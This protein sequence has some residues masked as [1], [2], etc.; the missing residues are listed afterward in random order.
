MRDTLAVTGRRADS[1]GRRGP[2]ASVHALLLLLALGALVPAAGASAQPT[3]PLASDKL[4][5]QGTRL[6]IAPGDEEQTLNVAEGATV[7]TCFAGVC[8]AMASGDPRASGLVV[9][10]D[11]SGPE[12]PQPIT[13][14]TV[15]GGAFLL[16]GF[17][18]EGTYL[19]SNIRL[20]RAGGGEVLGNAS[21]STV[22]LEVR[23]ILLASATVRQLTLEELRARGIEITQQSFQAFSFDVGFVFRDTPV[24]I[25]LPV[26]F[27]EGSQVELLEKPQVRLDGLP[28]DVA[29]ALRRWQPPSLIPFRLEAAAP[30]QLAPGYEPEEVPAETKLFGV[31]VL[32]GKVSFLNQFLDASLLVVNGAPTGSAA[33]LANVTG[34]IRLPAAV[35]RELLRLA[36]TTPPV[37]AGQKVPVLGATGNA[38]L[39]PSEQGAASFTL[40]GLV[41]GTHVF[42]LAIE[43]DLERPGRD[44]LPLAGKLKAAVEVVDA[45]FNLSFNHPDVVREGEPYTLYATVTNLS[46]A[47][48]YL[49]TVE[50]DSSRITGAHKERAGDDFSPTIPSLAPGEGATFEYR[51]VADVTGRCVATTFQSAGPAEGVI[52][53]RTGVGEAGIPLSPSSLVLP[54]FTELLPEALVRSNIRLLGLAWSLAVAPPGSIPPELPRLVTTDVERRAVDL[55]EAGQ[56]LYLGDGLLSSLEALLLDQ[57]GN[58]HDLPEYDTLR[59]TLTKGRDAAEALASLLRQEQEARGLTARSLLADT[60][61]AMTWARPWIAATLESSGAGTA[62]TLEVRKLNGATGVTFLAYPAGDARALRSIPFGEVFDVFER[63]GGRRSPLAVVGRLS[64]EAAYAFVVH[65]PASGTPMPVTLSFVAPAPSGSGFVVVDFPSLS[66][67]PGEAWAVEVTRAAGDFRP[68]AFALVHLATGMPV[69]EAPAAIVRAVELPPFRLIGARQ[70]FVLDPYGSGVWYLFNRPPAK[71]DAEEEDRYEVETR[72]RGLDST[73]S[74]E[75]LERTATFTAAS[76]LLQ[77]SSERVLTVRFAQPVSAVIATRE[78]QPV[79]T[80]LHRI[81]AGVLRDRYGNALASPVPDIRIESGHVGGLVEGKVLA[82]TGQAVAGATLRLVRERIVPDASGLDSRVVHDLVAERT[83]GADGSFFF[84]FVEEPVLAVPRPPEKG[85]VQSGFRIQAVLPPGPDPLAPL[86]IEEVSSIIRL[87]S[88]LARINLSFLGRGTL[89]GRAVYDDGG[90]AIG[91]AVTAASTLFSEVRTAKAGADGGFRVDGLPVG[92]ITVTARDAEGRSASATVALGGPGAK[93]E[94]T[95]RLERSRPPRI[96]T[97][98]GRVLFRSETASGPQA[99]PVAGARV[100]VYSAGAPYGEAVTG[101]AGTFRFTGVPAGRVTLQAADFTRSR[102]AAIA[103]VDLAAEGSADATLILAASS[104]RSVAGKVLFHD[105]LAQADVPASGATVFVEGPGSFA[106]TDAAGDYRIDGVPAQGVGEAPYRVHAIDSVRRAEG[107]TVV[108]VTDASPDPVAAATIVLDGATPGAID[109]VVLDPLGRPAPGVTVTL[110]PIGETTTGADGTFS[111][112]GVPARAYTVAAHVGAGLEPRAIGWIGEAGTEVLFG[113]HRAFVTVR[114]RGAGTLRVRTRTTTAGVRS[115]LVYRPTWFS[116]Q[117]LVIRQKSTGIETTTDDDGRLALVLPV[118]ELSVT[119]ANPFHGTASFR[120]AIDF[121]GQVKEVDLLFEGSS[122]VAG[123]VVDVDGITPVP[124]IDVDLEA[125]G[126]IPQRQRTDELGAFRFELVPPGNVAVTAS[127]FRGAIQRTGRTYGRITGHGQLLDL[128]VSLKPQ[129]TVRG[130]VAEETA[131]GVFLPLSGAQVALQENDFP[132]RRFPAAPAF[133]TAGGDGRFEMGGVSA[134]RFTVV[135]RDPGQVSRL[136]SRSGE[137]K[138]DFD[139][140]EVGDL[141]LSG[142]V[143]ALSVLVRDPQ[144]G[145]PVPDAQVFLS[146]GEATVA[147]ADG[148]ASFQALSLGTY[149]AHVFHAP[150]GRGGRLG[151]IHLDHAG[152]DLEVVVLL[153]QRGR[154]SGVLFDD[155][156][157]TVPVGGGTVRLEGTVNGRLWGA[158]VTALASTSR[159]PGSSGTFAFDGLPVATYALSAGV[160]GSDRQAGEN[161]VLTP[162]AP[163]A[164][165]ALVLEPIRDVWVRL[166]SKEQSRGLVEV[167]PDP[168]RGDGVF[169]ISYGRHV[170]I[171]SGEPIPLTSRLAPDVP[172][173]GHAYRFRDVLASR[174]FWVRALESS[175][176]QRRA[177]V[178]SSALASG[179]GA[180]ADPYRI[181]L[182]ARGTVRVAV[183]D[184]GGVAA[185]GANVRVHA[186]NGT[187]EGAADAAGRA[188]FTAVEEGQV[189]V[190]ASV[191]GTPLGASIS[192]TLRWDD[193]VLD[194]TLTLSPV[195]SA[196]GTVHEAPGGDAWSGDPASLP[197]AGGIFVRIRPS[198][199]DEQLLVTS[200]DGAFRFSGL[201]AGPY[202]LEARSLD[203]ERVATA[204]GTL[205]SAHGTDYALPPVVLDGSR[206]RIVSVTPPNGQSLVSRTA[207]VE[208]V[209][210]EPLATAV[211]PSGPTSSTFRLSFSS[212]QATGTW[213]SSLDGAGRQVVRFTPSPRY[214]NSTTYMLAMVGGSGGVRDREGR[215]LT[216]S[217]DVGSSF[218]TSDTDGPRVVA[219]VPSLARPVDP[220]AQVRV[221]FGEILALTSAQLEAAV[222][223]EWRNGAGTWADFPVATSLTRG[224]YSILVAQPQG[225]TFTDDSLRRRLVVTGLTD[226]AGNPMP[227]WVG[228]YRIYDRNAPVLSIDLPPNAPT[229]DLVAAARYELSPSFGNLDDVTPESAFG[230]LDRVEFSFAS[231]AEPTQPEPVPSA[232]VRVAPFRYGF[233]AAYTGDGVAPRPFP[234]WARAFD[235]SGNASGV[236]R[237]EMRVL[238]NAP[239]TIAGVTASASG[240]VVGVF[241]AGSTVSATAAGIADADDARLT[242]L[243][244]LRRGGPQGTILASAPARTLERPAGGWSALAPQV[245]SFTV[246]LTEAEG[247]TLSVVARV[248]DGKGATGV[249]EATFAVADDAGTPVLSDLVARRPD[250]STATSFVIGDSFVLEVRARDAETAIRSVAIATAGGVFPAALDAVRVATTDVFRTAAVTVPGSLTVPVTIGVTATADDHGGNQATRTTTLEAAPGSDPNRPVA[251]WLSPFEGALWPAGYISVDAGKSGVDLLLRVRITDSDVDA[252]GHTIPGSYVNVRVRGPVDATGSIAADSI[253]AV[254]LSGSAGEWV[255]EAAWR[256]PNGVPAGTSLPFEVEVVDAGANRMVR[257]ATLVA[258]PARHVYE[259]ATTS[260]D[261][262]SDVPMPEGAEA[263]P[264][265][266]LDG[267]TLSLYPPAA[268]GERSF[269]GLHLYSGGTWSA[270]AES[271][272]TV[273]R[274]ILTSPEVTT[275]GSLVPFYP[276]E[277]A[278]GG[279]LAIAHGA[280]IDVT[281][282]GLLGGDG[283]RDPVVLPGERASAPGSAGSHGGRGH[284]VEG[285]WVTLLSAPGSVYGSVREPR[286]PGGGAG[287]AGASGGGVV[288]IDASSAIVRLFGDLAAD[289]GPV[290]GG[291]SVGAA[292]GSVRLRAGRIEGRGSVHANG[293]FTVYGTS[294][295]GGGGGRVAVSWGEPQSPGISVRAEGAPS[296]FYRYG[297]PNPTPLAGAGTVFL[298]RLGAGGVP[299]DRGT[300]RIS[301]PA[302]TYPPAVTPLPGLGTAIVTAID[303]AS[304]TLTVRAADAAGSIEGESVVVTTL[305][306]GDGSTTTAVFPVATEVRVSGSVGSPDQVL[307][308]TVD[309]PAGDLDAT[310]AALAAGG[311]VTAKARLRFAAFEATGAVRVSSG[312]E[313]EVG[314][315]LNDRA[316]LA[317]AADSRV[318][319]G[320]LPAVD[321]AGTV[322][323]PGSAVAQAGAVDVRFRITD[324]LGISKVEE[325][326]S[327]TGSK[328]T[329]TFVEPTEVTSSPVPIHLV[330]PANQPPGPVTYAVRT[331]DRAGRISERTAT[332]NVVGDVT[333]PVITAVDLSPMRP[334][335]LYVAG[336]VVAITA[337]ATDD[338][339]VSR[340]RIEVGGRTA[341][342][343]TSPATLVWIAPPAATASTFT[344][345]VTA[346]DL[347]GNARTASRSIS[348]SPRADVVPPSVS[349]DCPSPGALLPSG[350]SSFRVQAAASDD[351]GVQRVEVFRDGDA[352]PT[353]VVEASSGSTRTF[354]TLTPGIVLPEVAEPTPVRLRVRA[355][356][357]GG[358]VSADSETEVTVVPAVPVSAA[359]PND[360]QA[361]ETRTAFLASG[362]LVLDEPRTFAGLLVLRGASVAHSPGGA[363]RLTLT[364]TGPLFVEC[365]GSIDVTGRGYPEGGT[366][367]GE[368]APM[369]GGG[370]HVGTGGA[371]G[372][373]VRGSTFGSVKEP[374][375]AGGGGLGANGSSSGGGVVRI[376]AGTLS[377]G[378]PTASILANGSVDGWQAGGGGSIWITASSI[379]GNGLIEASSGGTVERGGGGAVAIEYGTATGT[380]LTRANAKGGGGGLAGDNGGAGTVLLR[381]P[382]TAYGVLRI[383][384]GGTTG[385]ATVLPS[386]GSGTAQPGSSGATLVTDRGIAIPA[387]FKGHEVEVTRGGILL[388]TWRIATI[389]DRTVT[390]EPGGAGP[391]ALQAGDLWQGAYRFDAV[392]VAGAS[393]LQSLDPIRTPSL[394]LAG[395]TASG[396]VT[397]SLSPLNAE[398]VSVA[399]R[400]QVSAITATDLTV[401]SGAT[402]SH[403]SSTAAGIRDLDLK[404]SG[405]LTIEEGGSIDV[406]GRGYPADAAYPGAVLPLAG[407]GSHLGT[408]GAYEW[409]SRG[410]TYGSVGSPKEAGGGGRGANGSASG[411]GVVRIRSGTLAFGGTTASIISNGSAYGWQ[412]GAG[413]SIWITTSS[414]TGDGLIEA[415]GGGPGARGGGGAVALEY[416]GATGTA[417]SRMNARGG[418]GGGVAAEN[419][420]AGTVFEKGPGATYGTLRVNNL[421]TTGQATVLPS[422]GSGTAQV[423]TSG[424]TLVTDR[425]T[426]IPAFFVGHRV[427]VSRGGALLGTWRIETIAGRTVMLEP[428]GAETI[429]LQAGDL[430]QG[431]YQ[432]DS[433]EVAGGAMLQ[434]ADPIRDA[435]PRIAIT[436]PA[437]GASFASG[438]SIAVTYGAADDHP[439]V[440]VTLRLGGSTTDI[441]GPTATSGVVT[442]PWVSSTTSLLLEATVLDS[443]GQ[444]A[445]TS[446]PITVLA[447][448][449][450]TVSIVEPASGAVL[451]GGT[452]EPVRLQLS[453]SRPLRKLT[454]ALGAATSEFTGLAGPSFS[455]AL[456]V[457]AVSSDEAGSLLA[458]VEDA[459]G[460]TVSS[461]PVSMTLLADSNPRVTSSVNVP[462]PVG[463]GASV[464]VGFTGLFRDPTNARVQLRVTGAMNWEATATGPF[465]SAAPT[466]LSALATARPFS[467]SF[468]SFVIPRGARG[469]MTIDV[470]AID[471]AGRSG[472]AVAIVREVVAPQNGPPTVTLLDPSPSGDTIVVAGETLPASVSVNDDGPVSRLDVALGASRSSVP[473]PSVGVRSVSVPVPAVAEDQ[474]LPLTATAVDDQGLEGAADPAPVFVLT[475]A[476][477]RV[478]LI[479][480]PAGPYES[481]SS[482]LVSLEAVAV[483]GAATATLEVSGAM[484]FSETIAIAGSPKRYAGAFSPVTIPAGALGAATA[485]VRVTDEVG[486]YGL[487]TLPLQIGVDHAPVASLSAPATASSGGTL[488]LSL[489]ASDDLGLRSARLSITGAFE[490]AR[491]V[492]LGSPT[493]EVLDTTRTIRIPVPPD[494]LGGAVVSVEVDDSNGAMAVAGPKSVSVVD[495]KPPAISRVRSPQSALVSGRGGIFAADVRDAG[496]IVEVRFLLDGTPF[497]S[498]AVPARQGTFEAG[499]E[500]LPATTEPRPLVFRVE[501]VDAAGNSSWSER[502]FTLLPAGT[503]GVRLAS[504]SAGALAIAGGTVALA[505][506][507]EHTREISQLRFFREGE[508]TPFAT[509]PGGERYAEYTIPTDATAGSAVGFRVEATDDLGR[510]GS[511]SSS[512]RIVTGD[513]LEAGAVVDAT[514]VSHDDRNVVVGGGEVVIRGHHRFA[515][516]VVLTN[517][518]VHCDPGLDEPCEIDL[519]VSGDAYIAFRGSVGASGGGYLGGYQGPNITP[520]GRTLPGLPGSEA[521]AGGSYG[522]RGEAGSGAVPGPPYGNLRRPSLPGAGGGADGADRPGGSG[523]GV[524]QLRVGGQFVLDGEIDV[525]GGSG[526][527]GGVGAGGSVSVEAGSIGGTGIVFAHGGTPWIRAGQGGSAGGGRIAFRGPLQDRVPGLAAASGPQWY[528]SGAAG[529]IFVSSPDDRDGHLILDSGWCEQPSPTEL[530]AIGSGVVSSVAG[531]SIQAAGSQ[532]RPGV[533]GRPVEVRRGGEL[534]GRFLVDAVEVA[535]RILTLDA[536]ADGQLLPGDTY[537]GVESFDS[538]TVGGRSRLAT[539]DLLEG[540]LDVGSSAAIAAPNAS[541]PP[542]DAAPTVSASIPTRNVSAGATIPVTVQARDDIGLD[543]IVLWLEWIDGTRIEV[544]VEGGATTFDRTLS[545]G[546]PAEPT[547]GE[548]YLGVGVFD[549]VGQWTSTLWRLIVASS[550]G[551]R[552]TTPAVARPTSVSTGRSGARTGPRVRPTHPVFTPPAPAAPS[553]QR[554][555]AIRLP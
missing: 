483:R 63:A 15:P 250:G 510:V 335:D 407:G 535:A 406:T 109:G 71:A 159:E 485:V 534:V 542:T 65:G 182:L 212:A 48:Q 539:T 315:I 228:E 243:A 292:G 422:L 337:R 138:A 446:I 108:S 276:L 236:A 424:V 403:P 438:S 207:P 312:D 546:V 120:G 342:S 393:R 163:E 161:V 410:T 260:I 306:A 528:S 513:L 251:E 148:R 271:T 492:T 399:G 188:V 153:D 447:P 411:G 23:Q 382:G 149:A 401:K 425:G 14:S 80:N 441:P 72:F 177:F 39:G 78:G 300:L 278:I 96:G 217:G 11:L 193:E 329:R 533:E 462:S 432:F 13:Y 347:A 76:A 301:N 368:V 317:I 145:A 500:P 440:R 396:G 83:T 540:R 173:P 455:V 151:E 487:A 316:A 179:T 219:T 325:T 192:R 389:S 454:L 452:S 25:E 350:Y 87:Q 40:E 93:V 309:A 51:L 297:E 6:S 472:P 423:G 29:A 22:V 272:V 111:F 530:V 229:G 144:N 332:W 318:L 334:G 302:S 503:P 101:T 5:I 523:G 195:V 189:S 268:G 433:V 134:G 215:S 330:V 381:G 227:E 206:P 31:I 442:A 114:L 256:V 469:A 445:S 199:G 374:Q 293:S 364:V 439:V 62:P 35:P 244:E 398:T 414:I 415:G 211:L 395:P 473:N 313:L 390:L 180:S 281:G 43:A 73:A 435:A 90:A 74:G 453:D 121:A 186:P 489:A 232:I 17:Q 166:F 321:F 154:V 308:L 284:P 200:G 82:G 106:V 147:G 482:F 7:R 248:T 117:E 2:L 125:T 267:S 130:R 37:S 412:A 417:L 133:L 92:P 113:G 187:W 476:S 428:N 324:P 310:A 257:T 519:E 19:L 466:G 240:P 168:V 160:E 69:S 443:T 397:E 502:T 365:G 536:D 555:F 258:V 352:T 371:Y 107:T 481:G 357:F 518:F 430:W 408:G 60:A 387:F 319:L 504:P 450:M 127:G 383:D 294:R 234:V 501:A 197:P 174:S 362:T 9:Q 471:G 360:W 537:V 112:E 287:R 246:P 41:P 141:V 155:A 277:L 169:A 460:A 3:E 478:G 89:T 165:V 238:P 457:P 448:P 54:R 541:V 307:V 131:P 386:L 235:T 85:T 122:T 379:Q 477:P 226:V 158:G 266:L 247:S 86:E 431:V 99:E 208:I 175:G 139:V 34:A 230:D 328:S 496:R 53:L 28:G 47:T 444:S 484:T 61:S 142:Q 270:G 553:A 38:R 242:L 18:S 201:A 323:A 377:L 474:V 42:T 223:F 262:G 538:V 345:T 456:P 529:T 486:L 190:S 511:A 253:P 52:R 249:R 68:L 311:A 105:P 264:V 359:G 273:R 245:L 164:Q 320:E 400:V 552:A 366:Y 274:T 493:S 303:S 338:V 434:S 183:R 50:L 490:Y 340:I 295:P 413:G 355:W 349:I 331:I 351:Q 283:S 532:W 507:V 59:R 132:F 56:R 4:L 354:E 479:L 224:G 526:E 58:R 162:T 77:P 290:P 418:G 210:S 32:P 369:G 419:G 214:E 241:Y 346:M 218:T 291:S 420:G 497:A 46:R 265:F 209:F 372:G 505:A 170:D 10:G 146:N 467:G 205:G 341:E 299:V 544:P 57:L 75:T 545:F 288:R 370:S 225:V 470:T 305:P 263:L 95:L 44:V 94:T 269:E 137:L 494:A 124:G 118:G 524:V 344:I 475:S 282:H 358:N 339:Q 254:L 1:R 115:P 391:I 70:D 404:V 326:W 333:P 88:R 66:V 239:P 531:R 361:L 521:G 185:G 110:V 373:G 385:Q 252:G 380:A 104:P 548:Y 409:G 213:S 402:L 8:G 525:E 353:A 547:T 178:T 327:V 91:A 343:E 30:D 79:V 21:P 261:S 392:E 549:S 55:A 543:R 314:G 24:T 100:A 279:T 527:G 176:E 203:G 376:Q 296:P 394:G 451:I 449:P 384:N 488:E 67:P 221:D 119:A 204:A 181:T 367:P 378:G 491:L 458:T 45:R 336:D 231:A 116:P 480:E 128:V 184:A 143:A 102:T 514:D 551:L 150:S 495:G 468:P 202:T 421:G 322:P 196:H 522:G 20:A 289:G 36:Q 220:E 81:A 459:S 33:V 16:P 136:G 506:E 461:A 216:D 304:R 405:T 508:A 152:Q 123:L 27:Q 255:Y 463:A 140:V 464:V 515:S 437:P 520:V 356:D 285:D 171:Y 465:P 194:V 126:Y 512:V 98:S 103:D 280:A 388:G 509:L 499:I 135:A 375:E 172:Y 97:V 84:P 554:P 233:V 517:S 550:S 498:L 436:S 298:E 167:D 259:S 12:L 516:L 222:R 416:A 191:P 348:V 363:R 26:L 156:T 286:L 157:R 237:L 129:G 198:T 49:V 429:A 426:A 427:E 275:R 64:A